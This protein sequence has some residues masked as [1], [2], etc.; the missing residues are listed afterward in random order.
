MTEFQT[1]L[2]PKNINEENGIG[3]MG[4]IHVNKFKIHS[5]I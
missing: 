4:Q 5:K 3:L 2:Q 1:T